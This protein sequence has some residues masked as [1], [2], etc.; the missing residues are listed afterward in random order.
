MNTR[1]SLRNLLFLVSI[2]AVVWPVVLSAADASVYPDAVLA[3]NPIAYWRLGEATG[4]TTAADVLS[5]NP[6]TY[7]GSVTLGQAGIAV[8]DGNTAARLSGGYV[9]IPDAPELNFDQGHPDY[10]E[11]FTLE[12]WVKKS[13]PAFYRRVVDKTQAGT[14]NGYGFDIHDDF[15]RMLGS[16]NAQFNYDTTGN[17]S[18][19]FHIAAV[20]D[21]AGTGE[22]FVNGKSIGTSVYHSKNPFSGPLRIGA[23]STGGSKLSATVDEVAVYGAAL[24]AE[25]IRDHTIA[26]M[27]VLATDGTPNP[28]RPDL[29]LWLDADD[30]DTLTLGTGAVVEG[31]ADKSSYGHDAAQSDPTLRPEWVGT[32]GAGNGAIRFDGT[33]RFLEGSVDLEAEKTIFVVADDRGTTSSIGGTIYTRQGGSTTSNGIYS[34]YGNEYV[35]D[36]SG[37]SAAVS[38]SAL[39]PE[40]LA[41]ITGIY[42]DPNDELEI[43]LNGGLQQVLDPTNPS[44]HGNPANFYQ[45]GTRNDEFGRYFKGDISE[46]L[47]FDGV[48][49][50]SDQ[51]MITN[52][53]IAKYAIPEP[54]SLVLILFGTI[55]MLAR[56]K[57]VRIVFS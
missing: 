53:L 17:T 8:G 16:G 34:Q 24:S 6:G 57:R 9:N 21:G 54:S 37:A 10:G 36:W 31:W 22:M 26:G 43:Y 32:A 39:V 50:A 56:T 3:D 51:A 25:Q 44:G 33:R 18:D 7:V 45:V 15:F 19:W 38:A 42:D 41:V 2:V 30:T 49:S 28:D 29:K 5:A 23:D 12:A 52:Y 35:L 20:S 48:L 47:I 13:G 40:G 11:P 1:L 27:P 55:G 14:G 4:A 46:I